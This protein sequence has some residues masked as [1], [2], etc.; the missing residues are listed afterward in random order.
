MISRFHFISYIL[1]CKWCCCRKLKGKLDE[2]REEAII[3]ILA[4]KMSRNSFLRY[5]T[6][7]GKMSSKMRDKIEDYIEKKI[8]EEEEAIEK[9]IRD[10][11]KTSSDDLLDIAEEFEFQMSS[12]TRKLEL[13]MLKGD[14]YNIPGV[15]LGQEEIKNHLKAI[16]K[17]E[18]DKE[19]KGKA[20]ILGENRFNNI[21]LRL[22]EGK[23]S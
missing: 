12:R 21:S 15:S 2:F 18:K 17:I 16:E 10:F 11:Q 9:S 13:K 1:L 4:D 22:K 19:Y 6:D 3:K 14:E 5:C 7:E 23:Q 20:T 8:K